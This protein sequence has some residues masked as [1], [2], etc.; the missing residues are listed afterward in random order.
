MTSIG[1]RWGITDSGHL[2]RIFRDAYGCAPT[3]YRDGMLG[4]PQAS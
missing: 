2:S 4:T 3:E 1:A